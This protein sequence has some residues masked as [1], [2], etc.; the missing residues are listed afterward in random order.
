MGIKPSL[1]IGRGRVLQHPSHLPQY[2][3]AKCFQPKQCARVVRPF[4]V[5][6]TGF[7]PFGRH[8]E[9]A[10][11]KVVEVLSKSCH[12]SVI[13]P[14]L[15]R[16]AQDGSALSGSNV[17]I[18][19]VWDAEVM[20]VD[21]DGAERIAN[22]LSNN[23]H[24]DWQAII[25]LGLCE[26]RTP[27]LETVAKN[28]RDFPIADNSGRF[29]KEEEIFA[30]VNSQWSTTIESKRVPFSQFS[31]QINSSDD[32]GA[33]VC[34]ETY[35]NTLAKVYEEG[36]T[37]RLGRLLPVVFLHLP[38]TEIMPLVEQVKLVE[39]LAA[40][41]VNR[42][43]ITVA[44]GVVLDGNGKSLSCRRSP[45][46]VFPGE[47]EFPGG[48]VEYGEDIQACLRRELIEELQ[49]QTLPVQALCVHRVIAGSIELELHAWLVE[50]ESG[51]I[52]LSVHDKM[53]W[54]QVEELL[55]ADWIESDYPMISIIG[56]KLANL[57]K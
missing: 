19:I 14:S 35:A 39:E 46:E 21:S 43:L 1:G 2:V 49:I 37:D 17:P 50:W 44:A 28:W 42:P 27:R 55:S 20:S 53:R 33:F 45:D 40:W 18:G 23:Y 30:G 11:E 25:H 9:N 48:K 4:K 52:K 3:S 26:S 24:S 6:V 32:A 54:L 36:I 7:E 29:S 57:A 10:S 8:L 22:E 12:S 16:C 51:E 5:R 15:P 34:N 31:S 56:E 47:W 13:A 38:T 41:M